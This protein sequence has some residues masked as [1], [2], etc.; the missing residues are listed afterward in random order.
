[1]EIHPK[2]SPLFLFSI[3]ISFSFMITLS[4][5]AE[6]CHPSDENAL[7]EIKSRL[8][9]NLSFFD[10]WRPNTDCCSWINVACDKRTHRVNYLAVGQNRDLSGQIPSVVGQLSHLETLWF[11]DMPGLTG[12]I[13]SALS[14]LANLKELMLARTNLTGPIPSFLGRLT[15]L[16]DLDL[17]ENRLY[18]PIPGSLSQLSNL[19]QLKI[20]KNQLTGSIPESFGSFKKLFFQAYENQLSGPVPRSLVRADFSW[21]DLSSN[22]LT[23]DASVLFG[24]RKRA[25]YINLNNNAV[26]FDLSKVEF[27]SKLQGLD[28]SHNVIYGSIPQQLA[29]LPLKV[30]N[31]SYNQ[32]CGPIPTGLT[33]FGSD[34]FASNKCLCG[35]PLAPCKSISLFF[36]PSF[37]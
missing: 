16:T 2:I 34:A 29:K 17:S 1:M 21:V 5:T 25:A 3:L 31:V 35:A 10:T 19:Q 11:N 33:Q 37:M 20:F 7:L 30:L 32:L 12:P 13:P 27:P 36:H 6:L 23:G 9:P 22:Q 4:H 28:L 15:K 14:N 8:G 26:S 18:G 24:R